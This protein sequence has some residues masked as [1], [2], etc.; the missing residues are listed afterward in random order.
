MPWIPPDLPT[1]PDQNAINILDGLQDRLVGWVPTDG[2]PLTAFASEV[3]REI[4][5]LAANTLVR[6]EIGVAG[7]GETVFG[8]PSLQAKPATALVELT[9]SAAATL[10]PE[11]VV[12]GK[13]AGGVEVSLALVNIVNAPIGTSQHTMTA[14]VPGQDGNGIPIGPLTIATATASV[15]TAVAISASTG[16]TDAETLAQYLDRLADTLATLRFGGV[17]AEDLAALSRGVAGVH[18]AFGVDLYDPAT[19][20]TPKERSAT[21]FPV[22]SDGLPVSAGIKA[23][24][25]NYLATLREVNFLIFIADPTYTAITVA[26]TVSAEAGT[27]GATLVTEINVALAR[28]LSPANWGSTDADPQAW[29]SSPKVF[30]NDLI[31]VIGNVPGVARVV[32]LT[33]NGGTADVTL[34]GVAPLPAPNATISGGIV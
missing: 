10:G 2:D 5:D 26:Y 11:F 32:S 17:R 7:W 33:V 16:G 14:I 21:V 27:T 13:T 23:N 4:A 20:A 31:R 29:V 15:V 8:V 3:G 30:F 18:R 6:I 1:D 25:A 24:L 9:L 22:G 34:A 28:Y 12:V 19:P